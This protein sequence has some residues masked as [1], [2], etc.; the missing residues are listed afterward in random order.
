[1]AQS[2][3][4]IDKLN[5]SNY[6]SWVADMKY[7]LINQ[8]LWDII[9]GEEKLPVIGTGVTAADVK[10]VKH[11]FDV[12]LSFIFLNVEKDYR[13]LIENTKCPIEAWNKLK[14]SYIP[15]TRSQH[16]EIFSELIESRKGKE[17]R[18]SL[19]ASRLQRLTIQLQEFN[20]DFDEIY[21]CFQLLRYL[22]SQYDQVVQNILRWDKANFV[23]SKIVTELSA[24]ETRLRLRKADSEKE[25]FDI[26]SNETQKVARKIKCWTCGKLGH[27]QSNC[28]NNKTNFSSNRNFSRSPSRSGDSLK[29]G[30]SRHRQT[31]ANRNST[32]NGQ[33]HQYNFRSQ[34]SNSRKCNFFIQSNLGEVNSEGA[35]IWDSGASHHFCMSKELFIDYKPLKNQH[36]SVAVKDLT[37]PVEGTGTVELNF[38]R[39]TITLHDVL[40]SSK[41]RKNLISGP[42]LDKMGA[43]FIGGGGK[44]KVFKH[45]KFRF[46]AVLRNGMYYVYPKNVCK[47]K[48]VSFENLNVTKAKENFE[49]L[50]RRL[51]HV[52]KSI[53]E[54]TYKNN[55]VKG[56]PNIKCNDFTCKVCKLNKFRKVSFK[57]L[58]DKRTEKPLELIF[59]DT[60]GP[61]K[62]RGRN[63]EK[64]FLTIM[65][66]YSNKVALY[67]LRDK[68]EVFAITKRHI[69]RAENFL[70]LKVKSF[71]SDNGGEFVNAL[72][73]SYFSEKG[74]EHELTNVYTPQQNGK[75]ERYNQTVTD[76]ARTLLQDSGLDTTFWPDAMTHFT[77]VWNRLCPRGQTKTPLEMYSG[78][79]PSLKHLKIFGS[80]AYV[81]VPAPKRHKLEPKAKQGILIGYAFKTKGYRIWL[82]DQNKVLETINVSF[83]ERGN[84]KSL[85]DGAVLGTN[86]L[87]NF[88]DLFPS[89]NFNDDSDS[90]V[91]NGETPDLSTHPINR[92]TDTEGDDSHASSDDDDSNPGNSGLR[93]PNWIRRATPRP[94]G[95]RTD[96]YY[97]EEGCTERI[98]S[99]NDAKQYCQMKNIDFNEANFDF[100]GKNNFSGKIQGKPS[101]TP[102]SNN[103]QA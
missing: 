94:T 30:R 98:R 96:I 38:G 25:Y 58:K 7:L 62:I 79:K 73:D 61:C 4:Y 15:D 36:L 51:G 78:N 97:Y 69:E 102:S 48:K 84:F 23:F 49:M 101:A 88:N 24:E 56:L 60:W 20:E 19:F 33:A 14:E 80:L 81:G 68:S 86:Q 76:G 90:D 54:H 41:L 71:R 17:E 87:N 75:I 44:V 26:E 55:C 99:L 70:N 59:A 16:M 40:H 32:R 35:W 43:R 89:V 31:Y 21:A 100:S 65:D 52:N 11:K 29:R 72:F 18:I 50:H 2:N 64:F 47:I 85:G 77:Y 9:T 27:S 12:A 83:D 82:P 95:N 74:I 91:E 57:P 3:N 39:N 10:K 45:D 28:Y 66:D 46:Q 1:M 93:V 34:R 67:P 5:S 22:P 6:Q 13:K 8:G 37:F 92:I 103:T 42:R 63:G 53:I